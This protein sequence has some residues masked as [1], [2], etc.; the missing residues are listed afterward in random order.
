M[1]GRARRRRQAARNDISN[2][3][4]SG[5]SLLKDKLTSLEVKAAMQNAF[6]HKAFRFMAVLV[7]G[8]SL[9]HIA[10]HF[11]HYFFPSMDPEYRKEVTLGHFIR[12]ITFEVV[13]VVTCVIFRYAVKLRMD[14]QKAGWS[15]MKAVTILSILQIVLFLLAR[16]FTNWHRH[17]L[18][19]LSR[20]ANGK[21]IDTADYYYEFFP[22]SSF[23]CILGV[24]ASLWIQVTEKKNAK[25]YK[26]IRKS[27][28]DD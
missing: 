5:R 7:M 3:E 22:V 1:G 21:T 15:Y 10:R 20:H 11:E 26:D 14:G 4:D 24:G 6:W 23:Y 9:Y 28:H 27:L 16:L 8:F 17:S 13:S 18:D 12:V 19:I 25:A 2:I